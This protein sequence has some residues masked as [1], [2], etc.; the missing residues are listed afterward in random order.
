MYFIFH[1]DLIEFHVPGKTPS[2]RVVYEQ[3]GHLLQVGFKSE[4]YIL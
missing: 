2:S 1:D 3:S 4:L